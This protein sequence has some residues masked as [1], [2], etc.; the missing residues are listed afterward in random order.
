EGGVASDAQPTAVGATQTEAAVGASV[1]ARPPPPPP[2]GAEVDAAAAGSATAGNRPAAG[3]GVGPQPHSAEPVRDGAQ[4]TDGAAAA[5]TTTGDVSATAVQPPQQGVDAAVG[6]KNASAG[7]QEIPPAPDAVPLP[8]NSSAASKHSTDLR[9]SEE[10]S[11]G[12]LRGCVSR[13][14]LLA[15]LGLWGTT[16]LC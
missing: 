6:N 1:P 16:A 9:P 15:L 14:L 5:S 4:S 10:S 3:N 13:L 11:D 12:A 8:G 7:A 2:P